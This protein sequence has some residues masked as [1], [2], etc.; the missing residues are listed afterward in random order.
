M[1][2]EYIKISA[3]EFVLEAAEI[4][5]K[6]L[7]NEREIQTKSNPHDLVTDMDKEIERHLKR[8]INETFPSHHILGEEET[9]KDIV[10]IDGIIWII[11]P[12][13]GTMNFVHQK[14]NFAISVGI[15]ENGIGMIGIVHDVMANEMYY[16]FR[17]EGA[18]V[19]DQRLPKFETVRTSEA[20]V[21]INSGW[22]IK[23]QKLAKIV[24]SCRGTRSYGSAALEIANV[25]ADRLDGYISLHL[26][27]WDFAAGLILLHEVGGEYSTLDGQEISLLHPGSI[28]VGKRELQHFIRENYERA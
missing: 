20:I 2:W 3:K 13:D 21:A 24:S 16:G 11:D 28:V 6:S 9:G 25:V 5:R 27:P 15:Y 12:I 23:D 4:I 7:H 19:N 10:S 17:G 1:S 26:S 18:Y 22:L 8:R 14:R